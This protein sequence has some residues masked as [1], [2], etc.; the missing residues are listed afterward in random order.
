MFKVSKF[1]FLSGSM[2][3]CRA[4]P[5]QSG[6]PGSDAPIAKASATSYVHYIGHGR[7]IRPVVLVIA[8]NY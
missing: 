7:G 3:A 2:I 6:S 4:A 8:G 5:T 1:G